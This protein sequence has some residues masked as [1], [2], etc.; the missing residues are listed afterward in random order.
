M[1]PNKAINK[2]HSVTH[3]MLA[4]Q[5]LK[6][7]YHLEIEEANP[8]WLQLRLMKVGD[9][10][11]RQKDSLKYP[12]KTTINLI[13]NIR[14]SNLLQEICNKRPRINSHRIKMYQLLNNLQLHHYHNNSS[15]TNNNSNNY[16]NSSNSNSSCSNNSN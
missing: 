15:S 11:L 7:E 2:T 10:I 12:S 9:K 1:V 4:M 5:S 6:T 13:S 3:R 16:N 8:K 14:L